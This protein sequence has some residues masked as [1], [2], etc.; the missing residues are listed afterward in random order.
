[1]ASQDL[2]QAL[3][4]DT[5][6]C[7]SNKITALLHLAVVGIAYYF[8]KDDPQCDT[9][10]VLWTQF[11]IG[12]AIISGA[13]QLMSPQLGKT[14]FV[15]SQVLLG[16]GVTGLW[17]WGQWLV[18]G[19]MLVCRGQVCEEGLWYFAFVVETLVNV[20]LVLL[21]LGVLFLLFCTPRII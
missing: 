14:A 13:L 11:L 2:T 15:V 8:I 21:C 19:M 20:G 3:I 12:A 18:Y 1:M 17:I 7:D 16:V 10:L 6:K 5:C 4:A 9:S